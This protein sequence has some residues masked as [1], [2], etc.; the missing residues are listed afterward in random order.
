MIE[1]EKE[2]N[3]TAPKE[4][5]GDISAKKEDKKESESKRDLDDKKPSKTVLEE[6]TQKI[7]E[8]SEI[9]LWLDNYDDIFSD[10]DPRPY[11]LRSLSDDF[12]AEAKKASRDKDENRLELRFL[13]SNN[14][15]DSKTEATIKKR[16]KDHFTKHLIQIQ[17]D[18]I[19]TRYQ[20]II[21][22]LLG[23][24]L[25][26]AASYL[27]SLSL[28]S[29]VSKFL[30]VL[31]EPAGWFLTWFGLDKI[32]YSSELK[33]SEYTFYQKMIKCEVMFVSY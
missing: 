31:S 15:R 11:S 17:E 27:D 30:F 32:F 28:P 25:I 12:L 16:L 20:A 24:T 10:F 23:V 8:A 29:F 33:K 5:T 13:I 18:L 3:K 2:S 26:F 4:K 19:K 1:K 22:G 9:S 7:L 6:E 14:Q 21:T